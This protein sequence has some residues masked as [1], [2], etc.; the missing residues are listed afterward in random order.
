MLVDLVNHLQRAVANNA[1]KVNRVH[2]ASEHFGD[3]RMPK[4]MGIDALPNASRPGEE[5]NHLLN[6]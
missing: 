1:G 3:E 6:A 5:A 4:Q 2:A